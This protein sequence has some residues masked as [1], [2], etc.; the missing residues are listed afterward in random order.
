MSQEPDDAD[1]LD[2]ALRANRSPEIGDDGFSA[3]VLTRIAS[4]SPVLPPRAALSALRE[5]ERGERRRARWTMGG[6][7][8][9]IGVAAAAAWLIG[10]PELTA[11]AA[12]G[13]D[14]PALLLVSCSLAWLAIAGGRDA[15]TW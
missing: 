11:Q 10:V 2:R 8:L 12:F 15:A 13:A 4:T 14:I 7:L 6:G 9:G 3:G 1:W 5:A